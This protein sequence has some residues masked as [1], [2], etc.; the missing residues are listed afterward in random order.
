MAMLYV[1]LLLLVCSSMPCFAYLYSSTF[2]GPSP[3]FFTP[4]M[5]SHARKIVQS[6]KSLTSKELV[7]LSLPDEELG[8][9][10]FVLPDTIVL[11]HGLQTQLKDGPILNYANACALNRWRASWE[12]IT[13]MPSRYTAE[14]MERDARAAFMAEVTSK[15]IVTNYQ[16]IRIGLDGKRFRMKEASV[17]NVIVDGVLYGQAATFSKWEDMLD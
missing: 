17:W 15:G 3:L 14:A 4:E 8:Q 13:I 7:S 6:Y 11:S 16:G 10:L 12:E 9:A 2:T 5:T 1:A